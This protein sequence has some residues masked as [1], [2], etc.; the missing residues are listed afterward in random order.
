MTGLTLVG[1]I[2]GSRLNVYTHPE[3]VET[4]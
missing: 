2:R 3:R 1:F 4:R